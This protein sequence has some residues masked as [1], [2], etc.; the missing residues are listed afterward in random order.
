MLKAESVD[1]VIE[2][3]NVTFTAQVRPQSATVWQ[4][5]LQDAGATDEN[6]ASLFRAFVAEWRTG[7]RPA[8]QHLLA[9]I[10]ARSGMGKAVTEVEL[11]ASAARQR[12]Y[13]LRLMSGHD[14]EAVA[15]FKSDCPTWVTAEPG[16]ELV[17][18]W[19]K[20]QPTRQP[21]AVGTVEDVPD[22]V[23]PF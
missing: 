2:A 21:I 5:M 3:W 15:Q 8:L 17:R 14:A 16:S 10:R 11:Q 22:D 4:A 13:N 20:W 19:R 23:I 18:L 1:K 6:V 9:F 7:R 12:E